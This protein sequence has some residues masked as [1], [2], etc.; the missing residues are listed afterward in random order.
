[1]V[2]VYILR[3][4]DGVLYIGLTEDLD[5]RLRRHQEGRGGSF[6]LRRRP[7]ALV[8]SERW[9]D[10]LSA[11]TREQQLKRWTRAKKEAI[12]PGDPTALTAL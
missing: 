11:R 7:V 4:A 5:D 6:T 3:C 8:Y 9:S 2:W 10:L 1:M 12:I